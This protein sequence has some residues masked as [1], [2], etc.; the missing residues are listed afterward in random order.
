MRFDIS[1]KLGRTEAW[2]YAMLIEHNFTNIFRLN[3]HQ[4]SDK[5]YRSSQPTMEQLER[6]SR[7]H[8]I[9]TIIN[10][11][12]NNPN[13]A[14]YAFEVEK[15][16]QLGLNRVDISIASRSIPEPAKLRRAQEV[17]EQVE[18]PIWMH[19]KAGADRAGI[20]STLFQHFKLGM[21]IEQTDQLKFWPYGHFKYS[22]AGKFDYF[23]E[24]YLEY[25]QS[26]PGIG[27]IEWAENHADYAQLNRD[28]KPEGLASFINDYVLRR[29]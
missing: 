22:K 14:Y 2:W 7:K 21:P 9:R 19:C 13:S 3:F 8:G 25:R 11:K 10:L 1:T 20:Y 23:L 6:Y 15:C 27:F 24:K 4:I 17:F 16:Q 18:Y 5:V 12:G 29:E 28:F 26:H